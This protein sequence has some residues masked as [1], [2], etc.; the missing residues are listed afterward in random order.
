ML[1]GSLYGSY[2]S[3]QGGKLMAAGFYSVYSAS[4]AFA[5]AKATW[6]LVKSERGAFNKANQHQPLRG[7]DL[8]TLGRCLRR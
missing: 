7:L 5:A 4:A 6:L 1:F 8:V 3:R 2:F